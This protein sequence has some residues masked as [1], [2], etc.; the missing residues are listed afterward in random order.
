MVSLNKDNSRK[1]I[2][3]AVNVEQ[4]D[5]RPYISELTNATMMHL[6]QTWTKIPQMMN[7]PRS[8]T[9]MNGLY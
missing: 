3:I 9:K 2:L 6:T 5:M 1:D 7:I 4:N 8:I